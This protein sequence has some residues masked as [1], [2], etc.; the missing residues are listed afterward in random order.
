VQAE[1]AVLARR[2]G[3]PRSVAHTLPTFR[4]SPLNRKRQGEV[5][6]AI[7]RRNGLY[8][9]Q[10]KGTYPESTFRL[11]TGGIMRG[12]AIEHALLRE[13]QEETSLAVEISRFAA[14]LNYRAPDTRHGFASYLFILEEQGGTLCPSDESEGITGWLEADLPAIDAAAE[15]LR[16]CPGPWRAW[17][18]F[19]ALVL[20]ALR[21]ALQLRH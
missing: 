1:I 9:L 4:F 15:R 18:E 17:G 3:R 12:E 13:T 6:M 20:D 8:L 2:Y 19:R 10:T 7:R 5:A 16:S 21:D 14:V 11:P